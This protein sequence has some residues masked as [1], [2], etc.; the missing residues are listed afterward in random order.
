MRLAVRDA[1]GARAR[2]VNVD[3]AIAPGRTRLVGTGI[4]LGDPRAKR[5]E[6]RVIGPR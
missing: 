5:V 1:P 6:V 3:G 2:L 4:A